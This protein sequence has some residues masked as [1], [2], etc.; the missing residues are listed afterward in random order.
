M[1]IAAPDRMRPERTL[2]TKARVDLI[3]QIK[4]VVVVHRVVFDLARKP[5]P[6]RP[7][8]SQPGQPSGKTVWIAE[9]KVKADQRPP[10]LGDGPFDLTLQVPFS[11]CPG[12]EMRLAC[13]DAMRADPDRVAAVSGTRRAIGG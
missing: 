10:S 5:F 3:G 8:R 4:A 7:G 2:A 12:A 6:D 11:G 13:L 9:G 1:R